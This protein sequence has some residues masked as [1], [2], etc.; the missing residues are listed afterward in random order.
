MKNLRALLILGIALYG[1]DTAEDD[2]VLQVGGSWRSETFT[3]VD[4]GGSAVGPAT[5]EVVFDQEGSDLDGSG[6][7]HLPGARLD[8]PFDLSGSA[9][10]RTIQFTMLFETAA[11]EIV[12]CTTDNETRLKCVKRGVAFNLDRQSS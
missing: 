1:C 12:N 2:P 8:L 4:Q 6:V 10:Q 7:L 3:Q 9:T 11:P 5:L